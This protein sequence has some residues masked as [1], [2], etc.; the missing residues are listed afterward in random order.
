MF[1]SRM[2][3]D[4]SLE[5]TQSVVRSFQLQKEMVFSA[6]PPSSGRLLWRIDSLEGRLWIVMLS[7]LRPDLTFFHQQCGYQGVFPSWDILDYDDILDQVDLRHAQHFEFY[8]CPYPFVS[9]PKNEYQ[10][11]RHLR[12]WFESTGKHCGFELANMESITSCWKVIN[13]KYTLFTWF[14]GKLWITDLDT[15]SEACFHGIGENLDLGAGLLTI[16]EQS[17]VWTG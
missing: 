9:M 3:L 17:T 12:T 15:F 16:S 14:T 4:M 7:R 1:L 6:F 2:A 8:A 10:D 13:Q 11:M 5:D